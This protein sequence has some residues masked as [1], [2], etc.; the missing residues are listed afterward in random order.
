MVFITLKLIVRNISEFNNLAVFVLFCCSYC[1]PAL[2]WTGSI[3]LLV[4]FNLW[5]SVSVLSDAILTLLGFLK[6]GHKVLDV[7]NVC[8]CCLILLI[9]LSRFLINFRLASL[10]K[11]RH[12]QSNAAFF[13]SLKYLRCRQYFPS[14]TNF[15]KNT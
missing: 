1:N 5:C 7:I 6:N 9:V 8:W 15:L 4:K 2:L 10:S 3:S 12:H 14:N 11:I 13:T